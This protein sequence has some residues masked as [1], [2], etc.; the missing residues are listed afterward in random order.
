MPH[1]SRS[2]LGLHAS[3]RRPCSRPGTSTRWRA[4]AGEPVRE[5]EVC[6]VDRWALVGS[7]DLSASGVNGLNAEFGLAGID[8]AIVDEVAR[9]FEGWWSYASPSAPNI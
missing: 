2:A 6:L 1:R 5:R 7:D 4:H 8:V 3:R 9:R